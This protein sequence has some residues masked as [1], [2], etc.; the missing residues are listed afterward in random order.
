MS[1]AIVVVTIKTTLR[2]GGLRRMLVST[3]QSRARML[4]HRRRG[5]NWCDLADQRP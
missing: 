3:V 1:T 4:S 2:G 5:P